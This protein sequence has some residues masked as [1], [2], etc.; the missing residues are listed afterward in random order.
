MIGIPGCGLR[1]REGDESLAASLSEDDTLHLVERGEMGSHQLR[2]G[3]D[4]EREIRRSYE[5]SMR[6]DGGDLG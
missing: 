1:E 2:I 4:V 6:E 3:G 5:G